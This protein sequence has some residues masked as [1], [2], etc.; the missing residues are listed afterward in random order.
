MGNFKVKKNVD[1]SAILEFDLTDKKETIR[2]TFSRE[3]ISELVKQLTGHIC[4]CDNKCNKEQNN[5]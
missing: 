2:L 1:G 4:K 3:Q 5:E